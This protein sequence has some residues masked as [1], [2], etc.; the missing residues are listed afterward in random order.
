MCSGQCGDSLSERNFDKTH[1][2]VR[3]ALH[4]RPNHLISQPRG[5]NHLGQ[6]SSTLPS[7]LSGVTFDSHP[8][9]DAPESCPTSILPFRLKKQSRER[10]TAAHDGGRIQ[11]APESQQAGLAATN[12]ASPHAKLQLPNHLPSVSRIRLLVLATQIR[13]CRAGV[14]AGSVFKK[15]SKLRLEHAD[16]LTNPCKA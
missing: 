15:D 13:E 6:V 2:L 5:M 14:R 11:V 10:D 4:I 9:R 16:R 1:T 12:A 8:T 3:V 7:S